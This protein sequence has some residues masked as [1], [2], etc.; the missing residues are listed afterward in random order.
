[1]MA[2]AHLTPNTNVS[3]EYEMPGN[4]L[5]QKARTAFAV[6]ARIFYPAGA[7]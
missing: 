1:M 2:Q 5:E 3:N 7:V 4:R 6:R